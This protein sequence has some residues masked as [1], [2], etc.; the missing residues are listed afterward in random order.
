MNVMAQGTEYAD[1]QNGAQALKTNKVQ[2]P[3][4]TGNKQAILHHDFPAMNGS[5][6]VQLQPRRSGI[7][8]VTQRQ[9]QGDKCHSSKTRRCHYPLGIAG[10][11][12]IDTHAR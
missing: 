11:E 3:L 8:E 7:C 4:H 1:S 9:Q 10:R 12:D 6:E 5:R 2:M